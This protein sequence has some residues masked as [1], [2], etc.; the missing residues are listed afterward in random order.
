MFDD[1]DGRAGG[2]QPV[3]HAQQHAHIKRMKTDG[4]L[5]E[6]EYRV[7]LGLAHFAGEFQPLGFAARKRRGRFAERQ[8]AE[9]QIVQ[10]GQTCVNLLEVAGHG[11]SLVHTHCH[12]LGQ[13]QRKARF[14]LN[15]TP[16]RIS[17]GRVPGAAAIR[18][19]D[20]HI[21][22]ELHVERD[23]TGAVARRATQSAGIV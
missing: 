4:R 6:H 21:R 9:T 14:S 18:A 13:T 22:Q 16:N 17:F 20:G 8:V 11:Q 7:Q 5:V 10:G 19:F 23:R 15:R 3:E 2:D 12:E 1:H